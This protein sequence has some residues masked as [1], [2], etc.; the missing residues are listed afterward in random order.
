MLR[1]IDGDLPVNSEWRMDVADDTG[2]TIL[3]RQFIQTVPPA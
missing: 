2:A 3:T 1:D